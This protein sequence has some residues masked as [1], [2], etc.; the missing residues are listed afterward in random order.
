MNNNKIKKLTPQ[1]IQA[2]D[3]ETNLLGVFSILLSVAKRVNPEKY[4]TG[5]KKQ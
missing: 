2:E 3:S 1:P 4:L 5:Y